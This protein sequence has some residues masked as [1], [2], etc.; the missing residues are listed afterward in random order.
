MLLVSLLFLSWK[1]TFLNQS[2]IRSA[3]FQVNV[4]PVFLHAQPHPFLASKPAHPMAAGKISETEGAP[5]KH[6]GRTCDDLGNTC[7]GWA[8]P[9]YVVKGEIRAPR[10][11]LVVVMGCHTIFLC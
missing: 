7:W 5:V 3:A 10:Q 9:P 1:V 11:A 6:V 4:L 2:S 8:P